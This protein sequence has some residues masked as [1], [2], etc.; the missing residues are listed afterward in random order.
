MHPVDEFAALRTSIRAMEA[1]AAVLR[2]LF[3]D[4]GVPFRS[5]QHEVFVRHQTRRVFRKDRLPPEILANDLLWEEVSS[6][7]VTVAIMTDAGTPPRVRK[8]TF[9]DEEPVLTEP[10]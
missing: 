1:R 10:F 2:Q 4:R 3:L 6:P 8:A 5:N 7:I 9:L